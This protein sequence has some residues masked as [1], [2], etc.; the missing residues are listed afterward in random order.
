ME[1]VGG[2]SHPS[3]SCRSWVPAALGTSAAGR[4]QRPQCLDVTPKGLQS[5]Q[6]LKGKERFAGAERGGKEG[7]GG[8]RSDALS[9]RR[10]L[11]GA[12]ESRS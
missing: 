11:V 12:V 8:R 4:L 5:C 7:A 1:A 3:W 10:M 9:K 6:P 2:F